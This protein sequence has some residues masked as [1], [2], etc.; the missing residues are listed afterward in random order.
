MQSRQPGT[1]GVS[2]LTEGAKGGGSSARDIHWSRRVTF[3]WWMPIQKAYPA[4]STRRQTSQLE[5]RVCFVDR[6]S[7]GVTTHQQGRLRCRSR[8]W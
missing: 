5:A 8:G 2:G 1:G 4:V 7:R 3:L 6:L